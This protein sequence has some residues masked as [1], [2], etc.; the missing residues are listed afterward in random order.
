MLRVIEEIAKMIANMLNLLKDGKP[1]VANE[2][3]AQTLNDFFSLNAD[4]LA[5]LGDLE[6]T[7]AEEHKLDTAQLQVIAGLLYIR[8]EAFYATGEAGKSKLNYERALELYTFVNTADKATFSLERK[9]RMDH[10]LKMLQ[11]FEAGS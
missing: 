11:A 8:A 9:G 5:T 10:I 3:A 2:M 7:L 1:E 6:R 4:E